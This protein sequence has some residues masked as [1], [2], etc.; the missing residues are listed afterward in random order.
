M[1]APVLLVHDDIAAI[2]A[3]RRLLAREGY[4][5]V[6]ATSAA[7]AVSAFGYD[8]TEAA[9]NEV[10]EQTHR[11]MEAEAIADLDSTLGYA[12]TAEF[13]TH[14]YEG[15]SAV[16]TEMPAVVAE[17]GIDDELERLEEE[18]RAEAARRR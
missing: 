3:V 12:P 9:V 17:P 5:V 13:E 14:P 8:P 18:V 6:L 10:F 4:E 15:E 11:E 1:A 7:D 16:T 2:A